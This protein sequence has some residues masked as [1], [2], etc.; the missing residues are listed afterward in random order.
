M[1]VRTHG[2]F[3]VLPNWKS[4][5]L[6]KPDIPQSHHPASMLISPCPILFVPGVRLGSN[7]YQFCKLS[8]TGSDSNSKREVCTVP[9]LLRLVGHKGGGVKKSRSALFTCNDCSLCSYTLMISEV[10]TSFNYKT[11][12]QIKGGEL[13]Q[14]VRAWGM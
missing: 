7:K 12:S 1:A 14:L 4:R 5:M 9:I 13:A 10:R 8:L 2:D 6:V 11:Q 3:I